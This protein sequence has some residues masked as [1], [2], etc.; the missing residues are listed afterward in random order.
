MP[1]TIVVDTQDPPFEADPRRYVCCARV[2][3]G[4]VFY[5]TTEAEAVYFCVKWIAEQ[6]GPVRLEYGPHAGRRPRE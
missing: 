1:L 4:P 6:G 5:G 3:G 2:E